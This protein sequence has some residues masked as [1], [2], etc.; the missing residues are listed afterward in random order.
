[1]S[2]V[3]RW[4]LLQEHVVTTDD[5]DAN[6]T[7]RVEVVT[8]WLHDA[9]DA[10]LAGFDEFDATAVTAGPAGIPDGFVLERP[11]TIVV[12]AGTREVY[13]DSFLVALRLRA[14]GEERD[15]VLNT[16]SVVRVAVTDAVRDALIAREHRAAH[17]N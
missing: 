2:F 8:R 10:Y 12:S 4:P 13:E 16:A 15:V 3:S 9:R 1:M 14:F 7:V 5:L 17:A 6:G 11:A